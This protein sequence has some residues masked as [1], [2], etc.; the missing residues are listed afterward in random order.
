[1]LASWP[2]ATGYLG[3][4]YCIRT[5]WASLPPP[6]PHRVPAQVSV[7]QRAR[8][9]S[10]ALGFCE[11]AFRR[12]KSTG[13]GGTPPPGPG[14]LAE[15]GQGRSSPDPLAAPTESAPR[16]VQAASLWGGWLCTPHNIPFIPGWAGCGLAPA[17]SRSSQHLSVWLLA[18]R[19]VA[20]ALPTVPLTFPDTGRGWPASG[21]EEYCLQCPAPFLTL[22]GTGWPW[23]PGVVWKSRL[24][25][26][27]PLPGLAA[28]PE[29]PT[30]PGT[31]WVGTLLLPWGPDESRTFSTPDHS[32]LSEAW[33][34]PTPPTPQLLWSPSPVPQH[35]LAS[36]HLQTAWHAHLLD[37][38]Q[39]ILSS[40]LVTSLPEAS[41]RT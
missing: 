12:C 26:F 27:P 20:G 25:L 17:W 40:L 18:F 15:W 16:R 13:Q 6:P 37:A 34:P 24:L 38:F 39:G 32:Y 3:Q 14:V 41:G 30:D 10:A 11:S 1:M 4:G 21:V 28:R 8:A 31:A 36:C 22:G 23:R 35:Y 29:R 7:N 5:Y 2:T 19:V 33:S 9:G